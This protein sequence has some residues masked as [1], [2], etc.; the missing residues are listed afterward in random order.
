MNIILHKVNDS[1]IGQRREDGYINLTKMAQ[2]SNR[3][4]NDY[5]RLSTAKAFI[6]KLSADTGIPVSG[7][8]GLVQVH[9]GGN[10][11]TTQGTWGHP[12]V[13]INCGQWCSPEFAVL[14]SKWVFSWI[15]NAQ[16]PVKENCDGQSPV[17]DHR[18]NQF[19]DVVKAY[20]E[21]SQ[22]LNRAIH[23]AIHQ[24][25]DSLR[26][27]LKF[28]DSYN[29]V[30]VTVLAAEAK[31]VEQTCTTSDTVCIDLI[32]LPDEQP[33][34]YFDGQKLEELSHSIK[35]FGILEPLLVR[36]L[37]GGNYELI[38]GERRLRA[39]QIAGLTSVP[40]LVREMDDTTTRACRLIENLQR[41]DLNVYEETIGILNLLALQLKTT[42]DKVISLL[43]RIEKANRKKADECGSF[44]KT[45]NVV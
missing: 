28:L 5:L 18:S 42:E 34:R 10:N 12:Q 45:G 2:A 25:T 26:E 13:A 24:Q 7:K 21:S 37:S 32:T 27:A 41:E 35:E 17:F 36:P 39:S 23:T 11:K 30:T 9:K 43:N 29:D 20:I 31:L 44:S 16:N 14:V 22:A 15:A 38:A 6:D 33:R 8:N 40:V 3:K 1:Q 19:S 4:L